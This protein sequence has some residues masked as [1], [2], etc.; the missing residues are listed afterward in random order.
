MN[1]PQ[2]LRDCTCI[3]QSIRGDCL[4]STHAY[5]DIIHFQGSKTILIG[6]IIASEKNC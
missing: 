2:S 6:S 1:K 3:R 4:A 5:S